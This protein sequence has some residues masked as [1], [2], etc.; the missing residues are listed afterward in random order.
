MY[1]TVFLSICLIDIQ[2]IS[3]SGLF[4]FSHLIWLKL[5]ETHWIVTPPLLPFPI[6][7][8]HHSI[9]CFCGFDYFRDLHIS[10]SY[11]IFLWLISLWVISFSFVHV[12]AYDRV[13]FLRRNSSPLYV[14]I[15]I[16]YVYN[17]YMYILCVYIN[18]YT[19]PVIVFLDFRLYSFPSYC[20]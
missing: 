15:C 10:G 19:C 3:K 4:V 17:M 13:S 16:L 14:N 2:W 8:N 7:G 1:N 12:M 18:I 6:P 9:F 5:I 11:S 20:K